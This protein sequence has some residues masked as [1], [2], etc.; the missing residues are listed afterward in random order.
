[1]HREPKFQFSQSVKF[2]FVVLLFIFC[3]CGKGRQ[4]AEK[5]QPPAKV[6]NAVKESALSTVTLSPKA[7]E[8]LGIEI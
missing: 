3:S 6:E 7:E 5:S 4:P 2:L 8:R 1:M